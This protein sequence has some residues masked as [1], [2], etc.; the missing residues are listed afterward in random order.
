MIRNYKNKIHL[1]I[2]KK[3]RNRILKNYKQMLE[4][5]KNLNKLENGNYFGFVN[6]RGQSRGIKLDIQGES[7][8]DFYDPIKIE[9][10]KIELEIS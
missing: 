5:E 1:K 3:H 2:W 8:L 6:V 10:I 9:A 7:H 4:N